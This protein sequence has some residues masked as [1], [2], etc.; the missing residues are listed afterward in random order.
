MYNL[1][2][3]PTIYSRGDA[4]GL[5]PTQLRRKLT[6]DMTLVMDVMGPSVA[7]SH[8]DDITATVMFEN[9]PLMTFKRKEIELTPSWCCVDDLQRSVR[10]IN[11][12]LRGFAKIEKENDYW[13]VETLT[14]RYAWDLLGIGSILT[15]VHPDI[16]G[17]FKV[18]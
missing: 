9:G 3:C 12:L 14:G 8:Y 1:S 13:V 2:N 18:Y 15:G 10:R 7:L 6:R 4:F 17:E 16:L 11:V 5:F